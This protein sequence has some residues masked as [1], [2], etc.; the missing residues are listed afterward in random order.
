MPATHESQHDSLLARI[1]AQEK[2][3]IYAA[4]RI[5]RDLIDYHRR[6]RL[7]NRTKPF[8][9]PISSISRDPWEKR[10]NGPV[11]TR[12]TRGHHPHSRTR[13]YDLPVVPAGK[14]KRVLPVQQSPVLE[15]SY[16][17]KKLKINK[18]DFILTCLIHGENPSW[19]KDFLLPFCP[20]KE[21]ETAYRWR[22]RIAAQVYLVRSHNRQLLA[23]SKRS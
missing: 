20:Q 2:C 23:E 14:F 3:N 22:N 4:R 16:N 18:A 6:V 11:P 8:E 7:K 19:I 5:L 13:D 17:R 1:M 9:P 10:I 21:G 12:P 15:F